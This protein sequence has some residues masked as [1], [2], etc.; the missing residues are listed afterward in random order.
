MSI[1]RRKTA[2][3]SLYLKFCVCLCGNFSFVSRKVPRSQKLIPWK[4]WIWPWF[5]KSDHFF[6]SSC[7]LC[8]RN[9]LQVQA[10]IL[11][12]LIYCR[13]KWETRGMWRRNLKR[14]VPRFQLSSKLGFG[15][16]QCLNISHYH[17]V[18]NSSLQE[19]KE[20]QRKL[21]SLDGNRKV[22]RTLFVW[23]LKLIFI[24]DNYGHRQWK[25]EIELSDR[26][27]KFLVLL[28]LKAV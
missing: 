2:H 26:W 13:L 10:R 8:R 24:F 11:P 16:V 1:R 25:Y 3:Q 23:W 17:N 12:R 27:Q 28:I 6:F 19:N 9:P 7:F 5:F 14:R 21:E 15:E 22:W 4:R 18:F 20:L